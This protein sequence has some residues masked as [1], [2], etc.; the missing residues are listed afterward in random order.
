MTLASP[1][2]GNTNASGYPCMDQIGR[3]KGA[4]ISGYD[5]LGRF[6]LGVLS[7]TKANQQS[8]PLYI[9]N[10]TRNGALSAG[11]AVYTDPGAVAPNRDYYNQDNTNCAPGGGSCAA[12]VGRG[13]LA[14]RPASCSPGVGYWATDQGEW[15]STNGATPDGRLYKCVSANNWAPYYMPY[16]YPHPLVSG[17]PAPAPDSGSGSAPQPPQNLRILTGN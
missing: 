17:A 10:N 6:N 14:Q 12:G 16:A 13:T 2:D 15:N 3:G 7:T 4:M 1:F 5:A 11:E 9:W 8:E